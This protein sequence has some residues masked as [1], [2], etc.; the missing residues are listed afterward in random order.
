VDGSLKH[1]MTQHNDVF[2]LNVVSGTYNFEP[3]KAWADA[4]A[5]DIAA[6]K[7]VSLFR[8]NAQELGIKSL[9]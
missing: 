6:Q 5:Y 3:H 2:N 1:P 7:L 8:N 4:K 9:I